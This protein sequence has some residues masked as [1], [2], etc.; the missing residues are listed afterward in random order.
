M[1]ILQVVKAAFPWLMILLFFLVL[2]T[3]VPTLST[4]LPDLVFG[5]AI[6]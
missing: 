4:F 6:S 3:Y 5:K 1:S 2:V